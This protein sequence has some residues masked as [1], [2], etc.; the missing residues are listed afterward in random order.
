[1]S[2]AIASNLAKGLD[3]VKAVEL[4][5]K[6]ITTAIQHALEI[7]KGVGPTHHF[8]EIYKKAGIISE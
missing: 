7:G 2:A 6:Y 5:K 8:Y 4:S 3:V 1:L